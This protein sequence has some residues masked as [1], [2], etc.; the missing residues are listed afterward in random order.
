MS[1]NEIA[2]IE[3]EIVEGRS[4]G[5]WVA[6]IRA[7]LTRAVDGIVAAGKHL[8][9]AKESLGKSGHG[10]WLPMLADIGI[11]HT[12][13]KR[14]MQI[15]RNTAIVNG[16]NS[17]HLPRAQATLLELSRCDAHAL[18]AAIKSG[19]ITQQTT[20]QQAK[21]FYKELNPTTPKAP[22]LPNTKLS[23]NEAALISGVMLSFQPRGC[24]NYSIPAK[25]E[26]INAL[27]QAVINL[28]ES[29]EN[30]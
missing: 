28:E 6:L 9:E 30:A 27:K 1:G 16:A 4:P 18:E 29:L 2:V 11:E 25:R 26:L 14:L 5:E 21:E 17:H 10:K 15:G 13:A 24:A 12:A 7:D 3:G 19:R 22:K 8:T 23:K 20:I